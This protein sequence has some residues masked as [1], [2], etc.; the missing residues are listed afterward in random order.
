MEKNIKNFDGDLIID[1]F[2]KLIKFHNNMYIKF[3]QYADESDTDKDY[4]YWID[5]AS[6]HLLAKKEL[7]QSLYYITE[8]Q[9]Q[10][11]RIKELI[12]KN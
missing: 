11:D 12:T 1:E 3:S 7:E 9:K 2:R 8:T 6:T 4:R 5:T 10:N